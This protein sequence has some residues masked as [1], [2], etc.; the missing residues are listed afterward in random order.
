MQIQPT[1]HLD[2]DREGHFLSRV[3]AH[4]GVFG[5]TAFTGLEDVP[6]KASDTRKA[7]AEIRARR[8]ENASKAAGMRSWEGSNVKLL[9]LEARK[10]ARL[11]R[12]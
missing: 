2:K 4:A 6:S 8:D 7:S 1:P 12:S 11:V 3:N 10:E 9:A 5:K